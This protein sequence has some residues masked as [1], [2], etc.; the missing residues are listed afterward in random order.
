MMT[1]L[2]PAEHHAILGVGIAARE[3]QVLRVAAVD[4]QPQHGRLAARLAP[5]APRAPRMDDG[6]H[7]AWGGDV[8]RPR[9]ERLRDS[10]RHTPQIRCDYEQEGRHGAKIVTVLL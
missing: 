5:R 2:V 7:L 4:E 10:V 6:G 3:R 8:E 1:D 9:G